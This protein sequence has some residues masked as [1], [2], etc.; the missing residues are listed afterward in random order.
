MTDDKNSGI[1][2]EAKQQEPV[3]V[4]LGVFGIVELN[5]KFVIKHGLGFFERNTVL[6]LVQSCL[7][8]VPLELNH[9]YSVC[10]SCR[11][12]KQLSRVRHAHQTR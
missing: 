11:I 7:R 8:G 10:T 2:A 5:G 12:F 4:Q 9:M 3:F 1:T 6:P